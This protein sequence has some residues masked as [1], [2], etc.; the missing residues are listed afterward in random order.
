MAKIYYSRVDEF[1]RK[2]EKYAYLDEKQHVGNVEWQELQPD[3]SGRWLKSDDVGGYDQYLAIANKATK[4]GSAELALF[5]SY[6]RG[7]ETA[8]D[9]WVYNFNSRTLGENVRLF[10]E[11]Y[12]GQLQS[13]QRQRRQ[14]IEVPVLAYDDKKLKWNRKLRQRLSVG[15]AIE[16]KGGEKKHPPPPPFL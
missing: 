1:W 7:V 11:N 10:I 16:Y 9:V 2:E 3:I 12:D 15:E 13:L 14:G 8:R 5:R 4:E 6:G